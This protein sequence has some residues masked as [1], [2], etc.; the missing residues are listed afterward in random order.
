MHPGLEH[1]RI[2]DFGDMSVVIPGYS[3]SS[4]NKKNRHYINE[5]LPKV[6]LNTIILSPVH[7]QSTY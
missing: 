2:V 3:V 7:T 6:A 1:G 4:T 5:I